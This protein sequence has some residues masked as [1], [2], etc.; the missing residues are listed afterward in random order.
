MITEDNS[1]GVL[2]PEVG[3]V[4]ACLPLE[5]EQTKRQDSAGQRY[6]SKVPQQV[7]DDYFFF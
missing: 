2:S 1:K 6:G 5:D 3:D 7:V 4:Q